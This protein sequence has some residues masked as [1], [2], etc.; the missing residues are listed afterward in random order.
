MNTFIIFW[1][2]DSPLW[3]YKDYKED[4]DMPLERGLLCEVKD[5]KKARAGDRFFMVCTGKS[6]LGGKGN[7]VIMSGYFVSDP[8]P[9]HAESSEGKEAYYVSVEPDY[10]FDTMRIQTLSVGFLEEK[11]PEFDWRHGPSGKVLNNKTA[12]KLERLWGQFLKDIEAYFHDRRRWRTAI[13]VF[14][15][16]PMIELYRLNGEEGYFSVG[17]EFYGKGLV[18]SHF[19][20]YY[21]FSQDQKLPAFPGSEP[22]TSV[23]EFAVEITSL[24]KAL[25]VTNDREAAMRLRQEFM[26]IDGMKR[27]FEFVKENGCP[28]EEVDQAWWETPQA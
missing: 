14:D 13:D 9:D 4:F 6:G 23:K 24:R 1:N 26:G 8:F 7:G 16:W 22:I 17:A 25:G 10:T 21:D 28:Y 2:P 19:G 5:W 11:I 20:V 12:A 15:Y 3:N 18:V 27:L